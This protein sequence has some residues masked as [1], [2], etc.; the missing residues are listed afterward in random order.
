MCSLLLL[1]VL[2]QTATYATD[3]GAVRPFTRRQVRNIGN[4]D[5]RRT[6]YKINELIAEN[7]RLRDELANLARQPGPRGPR[8]PQGPIGLP[9]LKG[10]RGPAGEQGIPGAKGDPGE[11]GVPTRPLHVDSLRAI[12]RFSHSPARRARTHN[13]SRSAPQANKESSSA[14]ASRKV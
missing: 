12:R 11:Q 7:A 14:I 5:L 13:C 3:S 8:G 1:A 6:Y 4:Q 9:G 10:E 2:S